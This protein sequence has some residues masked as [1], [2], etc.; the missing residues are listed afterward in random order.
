MSC[1]ILNIPEFDKNVKKLSKRYKLIKVDLE[2]LILNLQ[3]TPPPVRHTFN[4]ILNIRQDMTID[5]FIILWY[6][7]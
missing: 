7:K 6:K 3:N 2:S 1:N 4:K 5:S